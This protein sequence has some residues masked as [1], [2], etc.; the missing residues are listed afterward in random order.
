M[1]IIISALLG[2]I[3]G[4]LI[5]H[6]YYR[7]GNQQIESLKEELKA[8]LNALIEQD[9]SLQALLQRAIGEIG[10][11][12][13][14][15]AKEFSAQFTTQQAGLVE[16]VQRV[17]ETASVTLNRLPLER[18]TRCYQ[19]GKPA[20]PYGYAAGPGGGWVMWYQCPDHGRFPGNHV[21]D[22]MDD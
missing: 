1:D 20:H 4:V 9:A 2:G 12:N 19:C 5:A 8:P 13:P 10:K 15:K 14:A 16:A 7:K 22:M 18:T 17:E 6:F 21:D 3:I 11:A